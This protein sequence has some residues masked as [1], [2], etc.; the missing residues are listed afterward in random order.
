MAGGEVAADVLPLKD[1][2]LWGPK[3]G[4]PIKDVVANENDMV[5][6]CSFVARPDRL[7]PND[8]VVNHKQKPRQQQQLQLHKH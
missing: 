2:G 5:G 1:D 6:S 7:R 8:D 4:R 3:D